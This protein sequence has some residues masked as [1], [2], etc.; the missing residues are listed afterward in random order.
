VPL[1]ESPAFTTIEE[2][3]QYSCGVYFDFNVPGYA[4]LSC[5]TFRQRLKTFLY[6]VTCALTYLRPIC[7]R[8]PK[9]LLSPFVASCVVDS[10]HSTHRH[11]SKAEL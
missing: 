11:Y 5:A 8:W 9:H 7:V 4:R 6:T 2:Y 10:R 3:G 1:V